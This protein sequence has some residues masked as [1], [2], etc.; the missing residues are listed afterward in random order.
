MP[1][2]SSRGRSLHSDRWQL[3]ILALPL[4]AWL[5]LYAYLPLQGLIIAFQKFDP[6]QGMYGSEFN[7]L[8]NFAR[9]VVGPAS[10]DFWRATIN[11]ITISLYSLLFGFPVPIILA[12]LFNET[13][14]GI[15][16]KTVQTTSYLPHLI[17]EVTVAAMV[18]TGL[19][20]NGVLNT[21]IEK[22]ASWFG[23]E[24]RHIS[25]MSEP[26]YFQSIYVFSGVWKEAGFSSIVF[27][28]AL[29]GVSPT[30]YEAARID[31]ASRLQCIWHVSLPGIIPTI[32]ITLIIRVGNILNVGFEKIILLYNPLTYDTADVLG[33]Y[34]YRLGSSAPLDYGLSTAASLFNSVIGFALVILTNRIARKLS[35]TSLW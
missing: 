15:F 21:V 23:S 30:L 11:T 19:E 31:G 5:I 27:F 32:V 28:A 13:K 25:W 17:S 12:I 14:E 24:Y 7:G 4:V 3:Y 34:T 18:L 20:I 6:Y 9:M 1:S 10:H 16:R 2:L 26:A 29:V 33:T 22:V 35:E 8:D